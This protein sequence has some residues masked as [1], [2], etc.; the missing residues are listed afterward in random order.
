CGLRLSPV[1]RFGSVRTIPEH[2]DA[3][4][5]GKRFLEQLQAFSAQVWRHRGQPSNVAAWFSEAGDVTGPDWITMQ[6]EDNRNGHGGPLGRA[7]LRSRGRKNNVHVEAG[8]LRSKVG[9]SLEL[10]PRKPGLHGDRLTPHAAPLS[11]SLPAPP[12][13][14]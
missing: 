11:Q 13:P 14:P 12:L 4:D 7:C 2:G 6:P 8:Q 9:Q 1:F 5:A 3:G 10:S